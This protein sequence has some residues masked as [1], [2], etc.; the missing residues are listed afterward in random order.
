MHANSREEIKE[1]KAGDIG[2]VVGLKFSATGDTLCES[3]HPVVLESIDLPE[4]VISVVIEA[5]ST[6][7][8]TKMMESLNRLIQEDP[9]SA[10]RTDAETGQLLLSGM[11]ELHLEILVDRLKRE[12]KVDANVGKPQ[13]SYRETVSQPAKAEK[14]FERDVAGHLQAA[15][16]E[17]QVE[18][19]ENPENTVV[20]LAA[21]RHLTPEF[22]QSAIKGVREALE[23]GV[24]A[25][26]QVLG[27]KAV[28][29]QIQFSEESAHPAAFQ[30][31][32]SMALREALRGAKCQLMEP[33][34][35]L[36]VVCPEDFL[37]SVI[38]DINSR[39]GKVMATRARGHLQAVEAEAP[40]AE[41]FGYATDLRSLTQGR[42][43]FV[44]KFKNYATMPDRV[45]TELLTKMG[46]I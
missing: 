27:V 13:V 40:L 32:A 18:K 46:R 3:A 45:Q 16:I 8:Q 37:G 19:S 17:V 1:L 44:M 21:G 35:F 23:N 41:L 5:K 6:A 31:A 38:G 7:Q 25:G 11:G 30:I 26:Y 12:F 9:S 33:M 10:L 14:H 29:T 20:S 4:P 2:A 34:F 15:T 28:I 39:R 43:T 24:I 22:T 42:G 36:E